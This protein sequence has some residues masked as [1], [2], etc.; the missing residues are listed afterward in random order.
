MHNTIESDIHNMDAVQFLQ[1]I[2]LNAH[3]NNACNTAYQ[4]ETIVYRLTDY[5][6]LK[7]ALISYLFLG[8]TDVVH[9]AHVAIALGDENGWHAV[10]TGVV[11]IWIIILIATIAIAIP[12]IYHG[13]WHHLIK[14]LLSVVSENEATNIHALLPSDNLHLWFYEITGVLDFAFAIVA[15]YYLY[16]LFT[17]KSVAS[18]LRK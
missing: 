5:Q 1:K 9:H 17:D 15:S 12:G 16:K 7:L 10:F 8:A 2:S 4:T 13:G 6:H 11:F 3:S 18:P 14:L